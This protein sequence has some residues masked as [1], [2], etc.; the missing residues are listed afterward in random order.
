MN[1]VKN[2]VAACLMLEQMRKEQEYCKR[3]GL[4][5]TSA[6]DGKRIQRESLPKGAVVIAGG[7]H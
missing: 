6:F 2:R 1:Y 7:R 5:D 3:I 4:V